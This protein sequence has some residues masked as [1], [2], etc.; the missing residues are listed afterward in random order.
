MPSTAPSTTVAIGIDLGTTNSCLGAFQNGKVEIIANNHNYRVTPSM[1]AFTDTKVLVG[2]VAKSQAVMNL[3][4]TIFDIKR[5]IGRRFD[6]PLVQARLKDWPFEVKKSDNE[7]LMIQVQFKEET[8]C[9]APEVITATLLG[10]MKKAAVV[11]FR[12]PVNNAVL[13]VPGSFNDAQREAIKTAASLAGLNVL[14]II[15]EPVAAAIA[16]G[17]DKKK[18]GIHTEQHV[19]VFHLGGRTQTVSVLKL[20]DGVFE[21][22]SSVEGY[23]AGDDFDNR[24]GEHF[25]KEFKR[26]HQKDISTDK[27]ALLRLRAACE[28]A[29]KVLS[30]TTQTSFEME[31]KLKNKWI[32]LLSKKA[33]YFNC[34]LTQ[35]QLEDLCFELFLSTLEPVKQALSNA[36]LDKNQIDDVV[37]VG[38][39]TR[40]PKVQALLQEFFGDGT[41]LHKTISPEEVVAYGA[42]QLS[43]HITGSHCLMKTGVGPLNAGCVTSLSLGIGISGG[44][45]TTVIERHTAFPVQKKIILLPLLYH[46]TDVQ[47]KMFT[48][49]RALANDNYYLGALNLTGFSSAPH[50][51]T[52]FEVTFKINDSATLEVT[53]QVVGTGLKS[54]III[55]KDYWCLPVE[56]TQQMVKDAQI[57]QGEDERHRERVSVFKT[58]LKYAQQ[59]KRT[60]TADNGSDVR[61]MEKAMEK[62][63]STLAWIMNNNE[64]KKEKLEKKRAKLEAV[65]KPVLDKLAQK[66]VNASWTWGDSF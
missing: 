59:V 30:F 12:T 58:F 41:K 10:K 4:N 7:N 40:I 29:K 46:R 62:V 11:Y 57:H 36:K 39:S 5:L 27:R 52:Q 56:K 60:L 8:K 55:P 33:V 38:G 17:L 26:H 37:F 64:A 22:K 32:P 2:D 20:E 43:G 25:V 66:K 65:C 63:E 3:P 28:C 23:Q 13:T 31:H 54:C 44:L 45:M 1:V 15:S 53:A 6:D 50:G 9:F 35:T 19:L 14:R 42:A 47:F 49:E 21:V 51:R 16:Y 48:G 24:L 18:S 34:S 61:G